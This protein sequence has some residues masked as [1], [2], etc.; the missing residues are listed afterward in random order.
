MFF[1]NQATS[2]VSFYKGFIFK[3]IFGKHK[4]R[5]QFFKFERKMIQF[6]ICSD[7]KYFSLENK[8]GSGYIGQT[9]MFD[10]L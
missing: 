2:E 9:F 1:A 4:I 6:S 10:I 5:N 3:N 8:V 7:N